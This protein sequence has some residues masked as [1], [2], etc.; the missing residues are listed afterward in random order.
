[1]LY[2]DF[3]SCKYL[4]MKCPIDIWCFFSKMH[5]M[6][7][8]RLKW[9]DKTLSIF[10]PRFF[11]R[12]SLWTKSFHPSL[13]SFT[14]PL[15]STATAALLAQAED[16]WVLPFSEAL[17]TWKTAVQVHLPVASPLLELYG[18][19]LLYVGTTVPRHGICPDGLL[20]SMRHRL[21]WEEKKTPDRMWSE[22]TSLWS[23]QIT[24][25]ILAVQLRFIY[26]LVEL[27]QKQK[28]DVFTAYGEAWLL[29]KAGKNLKRV[30]LASLENHETWYLY[31][32]LMNVIITI[33]LMPY[34]DD[35]TSSWWP[36]P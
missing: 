2:E 17:Q 6:E 34:D 36:W 28:W 32:I 18:R 5:V 15:A 13:V 19:M 4:L 3:M 23:V 10:F 33:T 30:A 22:E 20:F 12:R 31:K 35:L 27:R 26:F 21:Y 24:E 1:M 29:V 25:V 7:S 11:S 8:W 14:F 9:H 16:L